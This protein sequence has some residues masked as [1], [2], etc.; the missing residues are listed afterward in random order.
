MVTQS[1][2]ISIYNTCNDNK[3]NNERNG[4]KEKR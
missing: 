1:L 4:E 3:N 2:P